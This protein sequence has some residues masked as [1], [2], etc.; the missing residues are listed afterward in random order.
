MADLT[1][2]ILT[3][4]EEKNIK[5]CI[6][7]LKGVAKRV[8]VVDSGSTDRTLEYARELGADVL[9]HPME[10][11]VHSKQFMYGMENAGIDTKWVFKI[12]ADEELTEKSAAE[13]NE[14]CD[15]NEETDINGIVVRFEV[16]FMGRPLKHGGIYPFKK[17]AVFKY[18][19][20]NVEDRQMDEHIVLFEG[21]SV[22]L[23]NDS[24]HHD[25]KGL[26]AWIAKHNDYSS[27]EANDFY[28]SGD[29]NG[30]ENAGYAMQ[31]RIKRFVKYH[32]YY[33]L[34]MGMRAHLYYW[35]RYYIKL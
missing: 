6:N 30:E 25:Y 35:Y 16:N 2:I 19:K 3:Y 22:E 24:L 12:D 14:I 29:H 20:G 28:L 18:G 1:A 27:K 33:K 26:S 13:I 10:E 5:G 15:G 8:V 9:V 23:K 4:N 17:L 32:I 11:F 34:P 7:S 21:R 31:V